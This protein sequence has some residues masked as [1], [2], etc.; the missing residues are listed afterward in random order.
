MP[1]GIMGNLFT[2]GQLTFSLNVMEKI[3]IHAPVFV[4]SP[5]FSLKHYGLW[6][7]SESKHY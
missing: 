4:V 3:R 1:R 5:S 2:T 7:N 6:S